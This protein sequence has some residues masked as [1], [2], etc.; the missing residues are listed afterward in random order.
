L[1]NVLA[2]LIDNPSFIDDAMAFIC[3]WLSRHLDAMEAN[4]LHAESLEDHEPTEKAAAQNRIRRGA[5]S[6]LGPQSS[7][8]RPRTRQVLC[9]VPPCG[10][11]GS[12][13]K[14][15]KIGQAKP[16]QPATAQG[17]TGNV[18]G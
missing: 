2:D 11:R 18:R 12:F 15:W 5:L 6:Q 13:L 3:Q 17:G 1:D 10:T 9:S 7:P 4:G 8:R 16:V 14:V